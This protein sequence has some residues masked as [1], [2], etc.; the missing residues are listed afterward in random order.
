MVRT[1][2]RISGV[3]V[4]L[5]ITCLIDNGRIRS[6]IHDVFTGLPR[7]FVAF[8]AQGKNNPP[9]NAIK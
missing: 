4:V 6:W 7:E 5:R 2:K 9:S 3:G 1:I 8:V